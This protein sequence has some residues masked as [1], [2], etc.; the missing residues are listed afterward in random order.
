MTVVETLKLL[1][2]RDLEVSDS[3]IGKDF[4]LPNKTDT[5]TDPQVEEIDCVLQLI[6]SYASVPATAA[7]RRKMEW[8]QK[9]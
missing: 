6:L 5:I 9:R 4:S 8:K 7:T 1:K 2:Q 3:D